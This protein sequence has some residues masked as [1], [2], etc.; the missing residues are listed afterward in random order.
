[1][2]HPDTDLL[3]PERVIP[4]LRGQRG[5]GWQG[6]V[7]RVVAAGPESIEQL[8]FTLLMARLDGCAACNADSFRAMQGCTACSRQTLKRFRGSDE[9]LLGLYRAAQVD[10]ETYLSRKR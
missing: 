2:Y 5:A 7:A 8:A 10:V 9:D 6:L 3:F 1:M 4:A